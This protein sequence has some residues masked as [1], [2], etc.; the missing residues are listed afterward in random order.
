MTSSNPH[1]TSPP[2]HGLAPSPHGLAHLPPSSRFPS[3][4]LLEPFHTP[5]R[6]LLSSTRVRPAPT[7]IYPLTLSSLV[8]PIRLRYPPSPAS[9][10]ILAYR[11][12]FPVI[13]FVLPSSI[14]RHP[15][16]TNYRRAQ[17]RWIK[18]AAAAY[19]RR[20]VIPT[21]HPQIPTNRNANGLRYRR[22]T[23]CCADYTR[24][25]DK[26]ERGEKNVL[27]RCNAHGAKCE[28]ITP[29]C[30][31]HGPLSLTQQ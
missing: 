15:S 16:L 25:A 7:P 5:P 1:P 17:F 10:P 30:I 27:T 29:R 23:Q 26:P 3:H 18:A 22:G 24:N 2:L 19:Y 12:P 21:G 6:S 8:L 28:D 31:P 20:S 4:L 9:W 11:P 14:S 13:F